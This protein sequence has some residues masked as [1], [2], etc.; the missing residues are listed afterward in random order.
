MT[1]DAIALLRREHDLID[2][3]FPVLEEVAWRVD[4]GRNLPDGVFPEVLDFLNN[5][6]SRCHYVR[7]EQQ[8]IPALTA[9]GVDTNSGVAADMLDDHRKARLIF[10]NITRFGQHLEQAGSGQE[11]GASVRI[12]DSLMRIHKRKEDQILF[13]MAMELLSDAQMEAIAL[14]FTEMDAKGEPFR[15]SMKRYTDI[16]GELEERLEVSL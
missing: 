14:G 12:F 4:H 8:L 16:A 9:A 1:P 6:I 11:I 13:P 2:R 15:G 7:E 3:I 5:F 10:A